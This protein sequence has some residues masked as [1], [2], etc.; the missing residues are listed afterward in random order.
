MLHHPH[1]S[2]L[3]GIVPASDLAASPVA[4]SMASACPPPHADAYPSLPRER[5]L[6]DERPIA[7]PASPRWTNADPEALDRELSC[8]G[9][10][11][12][13]GL[14]LSDPF[15]TTGGREW[16][17]ATFADD[18]PTPSRAMDAFL[19]GLTGLAIGVPVG[20]AFAEFA[21]AVIS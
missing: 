5:R 9:P 6:A 4:A 8:P 3:A 16:A 15:P 13:N 1:S 21:R 12:T 14:G 19:G 7:A 10:V 20:I 17:A 11:E 2:R 18:A